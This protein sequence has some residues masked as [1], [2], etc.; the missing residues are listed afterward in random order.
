MARIQLPL[1]AHFAY[2]HE[3]TVRVTDLNYGGHMG[4]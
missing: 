1:P 4:N 2:C 3:L